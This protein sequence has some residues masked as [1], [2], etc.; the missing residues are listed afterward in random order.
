MTD[1]RIT[2]MAKAATDS[3]FNNYSKE[4]MEYDRKIYLLEYM[5]TFKVALKEAEKM[6]QR[7]FQE[8]G[9]QSENSKTF[10]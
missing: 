5:K 10:R 3:Y 2:F 1:E 9:T 4:F 7:S 6:E 8:F